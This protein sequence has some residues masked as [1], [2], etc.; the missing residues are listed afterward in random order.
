[1]EW[2]WRRYVFFS[3]I[4]LNVIQ[5]TLERYRDSRQWSM[6]IRKKIIIDSSSNDSEVT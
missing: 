6:K 2:P 4:Q 3:E 5:C 1:M